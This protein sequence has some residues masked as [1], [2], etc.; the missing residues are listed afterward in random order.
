M[1]SF[2]ID[3]NCTESGSDHSAENQFD[4][5]NFTSLSSRHSS[6]LLEE[7]FHDTPVGKDFFCF[8]AQGNKVKCWQSDLEKLLQ[9]M[10]ARTRN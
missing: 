6:Y 5:L 3:T 9:D 4:D 8:S 2:G 10:S 1:C 7:Y